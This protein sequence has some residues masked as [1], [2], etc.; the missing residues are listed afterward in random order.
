LLARRHLVVVFVSQ[1]PGVK[2][3]FTEESSGDLESLYG[4]LAGQMA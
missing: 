1:T 3:L 2:P 4:A